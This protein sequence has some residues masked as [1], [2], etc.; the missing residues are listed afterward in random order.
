MNMTRAQRIA[1]LRALSVQLHRAQ[2]EVTLAGHRKENPMD[3]W[4]TAFDLRRGEL[5]HLIEQRNAKSWEL[6][7]MEWPECAASGAQSAAA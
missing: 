5:L 7:A 1:E 4:K 6:C 3:N 2:D